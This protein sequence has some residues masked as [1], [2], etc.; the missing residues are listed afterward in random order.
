MIRVFEKGGARIALD[1]TKGKLWLVFE[2]GDAE[3]GVMSVESVMEYEAALRA[4]D[5]LIPAK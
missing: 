1:K 4:A 3:I 2:S 5:I